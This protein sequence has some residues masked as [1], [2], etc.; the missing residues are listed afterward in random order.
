MPDLAKLDRWMAA[1]D[2]GFAT[3]AKGSGASSSSAAVSVSTPLVPVPDENC[4]RTDKATVGSSNSFLD[5]RV[6][7]KGGGKALA[8]GS[9]QRAGKENKPEPG[10]T[11]SK[12]EIDAEKRKRIVDSKSE[13][14]NHQEG[15]RL[16]ALAAACTASA[17]VHFK[18]AGVHSQGNPGSAMPHVTSCKLTTAQK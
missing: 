16:A 4:I 15:N 12:N 13:C 8:P 5:F 14:L 6:T 10:R 3:K 17:N 2:T 1:H 9:T 11:R 18:A 7:G